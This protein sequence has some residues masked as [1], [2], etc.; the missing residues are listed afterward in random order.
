[1]WRS[2]DYAMSTASNN[3]LIKAYQETEYLVTQGHSFV[4]RVDTQSPELA[5]LYKA[6]GAS[7]AAFGSAHPHR[8]INVHPHNPC[9]L[10]S[11][12]VTRPR[13]VRGELVNL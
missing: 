3:T 8:R 9:R 5:G 6:K 12:S 2:P 4:L 7:C 10:P 1:M 13:K 11:V